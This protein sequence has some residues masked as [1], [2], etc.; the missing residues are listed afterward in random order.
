M[1]KYEKV[2]QNRSWEALWEVWGGSWEVFGRLL[3]LGWCLRG[4][5]GSLDR[6]SEV[7]RWIWE[8]KWSEFWS[9]FEEKAIEYSDLNLAQMFGGFLIAC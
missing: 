3:V 5:G 8:S 2:I 9:K 7:F 6:F 4:S 1:K